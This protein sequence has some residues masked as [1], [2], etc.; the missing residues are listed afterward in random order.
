MRNLD[1]MMGMVAATIIVYTI[2]FSMGI[3]F[4]MT[5][6]EESAINAG[7]GEYRI[8]NPTNGTTQFFFKKYE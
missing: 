8:V 6:L 4:G 3:S 7:V 2:G 1:I 5:K